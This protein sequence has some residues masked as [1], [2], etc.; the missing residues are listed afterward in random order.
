MLTTKIQ[1]VKKKGANVSREDERQI[2]D[3][4]GDGRMRSQTGRSHEAQNHQ[5]Q[6]DPEYAEGAGKRQQRAFCQF[7]EESAKGIFQIYQSGKT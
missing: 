1:N 7:R 4:H 2:F 6:V 5:C 3:F